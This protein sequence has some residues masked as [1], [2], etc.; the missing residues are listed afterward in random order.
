[1][2]FTK[3]DK[4]LLTG[5]SEY[6]M[7]S[8]SMIVKK[9]FNG[10]DSSTV[11][12]RLRALEKNNL[13]RRAGLL[14]NY[15]NLWSVT[16]KGSEKVSAEDTKSFWNQAGVLH[17]YKLIKLRMFFEEIGIVK[18]WIAEH[19]IRSMIYKK[20]SLRDAKN[21]LIP[22]GIMET[23]ING[24]N[25]SV[26]IELE[27]NLKSSERYRNIIKQYQYKNDLH[28]VWYIVDSNLILKKLTE[29][30]K[31][32]SDSFSKVEVY[33]SHLDEVVSLAGE[34][35][36]IGINTTCLLREYFSIPVLVPAHAPAQ[37]VV[38]VKSLSLQKNMDSTSSYHTPFGIN[39]NKKRDRQIP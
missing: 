38:D 23:K 37:R 11:L 30:W 10:I 9:Y 22:D 34:A 14:E 27:L 15:E 24:T 35:R 19:V 28:A 21:K 26:A 33:F 29:Y 32:Y 25:K 2:I 16:Q 20:Y 6:G 3:R 7:F 31:R 1:M 4:L 17:D 8:T 5:L 12:R 18:N 39:P 36:L 13:I